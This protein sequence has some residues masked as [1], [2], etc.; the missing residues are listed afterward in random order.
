MHEIKLQWRAAF[1]IGAALLCFG[2]AV[3][4]Q[5][6]SNATLP[7]EF[8]GSNTSCIFNDAGGGAKSCI[9]GTATF[10][11][12]AA[13]VRK[14][15]FNPAQRF[16]TDFVNFTGAGFDLG[17]DAGG[18]TTQQGEYRLLTSYTRGITQNLSLVSRCRRI[19]DCANYFY[20]EHD[21]GVA[22][23]GDEAVEALGL[24]A[25]ESATPY[26]GSLMDA[27]GMGDTRPKISGK[28]DQ[29]V[30]DGGILLDVTRGRLGGEL[31][32]KSSV[33]G[34]YLV[35]LHL[36]TPALPRTTAWG[37][38]AAGYDK[39]PTLA[40]V[41]LPVTVDVTLGSIAEGH[42]VFSPG[43]VCVAGPGHFEQAVIEPPSSAEP[44]PAAAPGHQ[45]LRMRVRY[46]NPAYQSEGKARAPMLFQ[47]GVCGQYV[48]A[49]A[50]LAFSGMRTTYPA[51][52]SLEGN[53]LITGKEV[54]GTMSRYLP[55]SGAQAWAASGEQ[56]RFHLYPGAEVVANSGLTPELEPNAVAW[57]VADRI[58]SPHYMT[59]AQNVLFIVDQQA[60]PTDRSYGGSAISAILKGKGMAG[61]HR[62]L[63]MV[64]VEA[65]GSYQ[66]YGG[67]LVPPDAT[68]FQGQF[69]DLQHLYEA[70]NNALAEV[71]NCSVAGHFALFDLPSRTTDHAVKVDYDCATGRVRL[72][73][74]TSTELKVSG[75]LER[76]GS[77]VCTENGAHCP[78]RPQLAATSPVPALAAGTCR[79]FTAPLPGLTENMTIAATARTNPGMVTTST[80]FAGSGLAGLVVCAP[81]AQSQATVYGLKAW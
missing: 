8:H 70:P 11:S 62:G 28:G 40:N 43:L 73:R 80:Y 60:S 26:V 10:L 13:P 50:D 56:S 18:W 58:E 25:N 6:S 4:A 48:S 52:A 63:F 79:S 5:D 61:T 39:A 38:V 65:A 17:G 34:D 20:I 77:P 16:R 59:V 47:G 30:T 33:F 46:P 32:G 53:D 21:G 24:Q 1:F 66:P 64:N 54:G 76:D 9:T 3:Q 49:D 81:V 75:I 71:T 74:I 2:T 42:P 22:A 57:T 19:G 31:S 23:T 29:W 12:V 35:Q 14:G 67:P 45:W 44:L 72:P 37:T 69:N 41:S 15:F 68:F 27:T 55:Q 51:F 36:T 78:D 7:R